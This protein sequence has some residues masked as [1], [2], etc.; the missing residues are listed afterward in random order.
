MKHLR[1]MIWTA[2]LSSIFSIC[3]LSGLFYMMPPLWSYIWNWRKSI[4]KIDYE[5]P[6]HPTY[7][8]VRA[9][10]D[11]FRSPSLKKCWGI[12]RTS[13]NLITNINLTYHTT[14]VLSNNACCFMSSWNTNTRHFYCVD[15]MHLYLQVLLA[16]TF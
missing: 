4:R 1:I 6:P 13:G 2:T 8:P 11:C 7:F 10:Q 9:P 5:V 3:K 14:L 12:H 16:K 15:G